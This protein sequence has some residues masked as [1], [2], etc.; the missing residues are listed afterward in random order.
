MAIS[1]TPKGEQW[2][3]GASDELENGEF[4]LVIFHFCGLIKCISDVHGAQW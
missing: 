2:K 3:L 1:D 4:Y